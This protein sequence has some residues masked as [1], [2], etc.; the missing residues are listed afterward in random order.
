MKSATKNVRA[1]PCPPKCA[2]AEPALFVA[3]EGDAVVLHLDHF[4]ASLSAHDLDGV[5]VSEVVGAFDRVVGVIVP[6]VA[7]VFES[8]VDAPLC[9]VGVA[10]DGVDFGYDGYV[11]AV[12]TG[13]EGGAH[14]GQSSADY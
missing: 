11:R 14:P 13:G 9:G 1:F 3:A 4:R 5:L 2:C 12:L 6:V 8:G 7:S 10:S